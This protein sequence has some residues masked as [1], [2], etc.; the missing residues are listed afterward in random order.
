MYKT[1]TCL[2]FLCL[3]GFT[4]RAQ[5]EVTLQIKTTGSEHEI[6]RKYVYLPRFPDSLAAKQSLQHLVHQLQQ[7]AYLTA[8]I[9]TSY[10]RHDTL[11][12][13]LFIGE[14]Y[15]WAR[16]RNGNV[17]SSLLTQVGFKEKLYTGKPFLPAEWVK[18]QEA[19]LS[20]AENNGYPF[21]SIRLD[22]LE[23][24]DN[25]IDGTVVI[26][27]GPL[28]LFDSLQLAG[29][30]KT[31]RKFL[32]RYLQLY[33]GQPYDQQK[34]KNVLR[35]LQQLPYLEITQTPLL[36]FGR[37][38][39]RLYL[40]LNDKK[41]NQFD[42][43]VGFLPDPQGKNK[44]LL[45]TGEVNLDIRN[46]KGSGKALG[47]HWR[48]VQR[49]SQLL[50][51]SYLHPNL[52]STPLELG[53]TFNLYK[54]DSTFITLKPR[55]QFSLNTQRA[56]KITFFTEW[57]NSRLL[58][59]PVGLQERRDS[60][61]LADFTYTAY[62]LQY[63]RH[64]LDNLYFP[65]QGYQLNGQVAIGN[66]K[67]KRN[68]GREASYYDTIRLKTTQVSLSLNSEYYF[69]LSRAGVGLARLKG[70][71]LINPQLFYNDLFRIGGLTTLRGFPEYTFYASRYAVG[72]LEYRLFTGP[73]SY[74][75]LFYDQGYYHRAIGNDRLTEYPFGLGTGISFS[76]G[77]GIFQFIYSVGQSKALNQPINLNYSRIHFGII[78]RF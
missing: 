58:L 11:Y 16:L 55:L 25:Q 69:K 49:G 39:A 71:A 22:S 64:T 45:V 51:A 7:D 28:I 4:C 34:V 48:K 13:H 20:E 61:A 77:A 21:A 29:N 78:S 37:E 66:K 38:R 47:L 32:T 23:I 15:Q 70:E 72:T 53:F 12:S 26:N 41:A 24:T 76:T 19:V 9:D 2:F 57:Q 63:L 46:L 8:S 44:K 42:G 67:I 50:D 59:S 27:K 5:R 65:R 43:I 6:L 14:R 30:T 35:L 18:L 74:V 52:L 31:T 75:L 10:L 36:Q 60:I 73:D 54:Q 33:A 1:V 3:A 40:F 56:G 68:L 17:G 62:G